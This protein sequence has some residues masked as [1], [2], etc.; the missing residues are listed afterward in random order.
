M[1]EIERSDFGA[2][3]VVCLAKFSEHLREHGPYS[4]RLI[5]E[6]AGWTPE[7]DQQLRLEA[8]RYPTG[9]AAQKLARISVA[10][11]SERVRGGDRAAALSS[12]IEMWMNAASDHFYDLDDGKAPEP[13]RELAALALN[14]G[15]GFTG[16][17]WTI[18][19]VDRIRE[20]WRESCLAVDRLLGVE[21]DWGEY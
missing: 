14:I 18:A 3:V 13:L 8:E 5:R 9:D 17:Q 6:Y 11:I 7:R 2:G 10:E 15:H 21:P 20:L 19:T 16:E 4:E 1:S 12:M